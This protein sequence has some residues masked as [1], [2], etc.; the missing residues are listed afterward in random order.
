MPRNESVVEER[1]PE[2]QPEPQ[3]ET[4]STDSDPIPESEWAPAAPERPY[5]EAITDA[6]REH[7]AEFGMAP[8]EVQK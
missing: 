6:Q 7:L 3:P 1:Q 5:A 4:A 8:P 2:P